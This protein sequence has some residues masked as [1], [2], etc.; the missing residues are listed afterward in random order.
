MVGVRDVYI[1]SSSMINVDRHFNRGYKELAGVVVKDVIEG[2]SVE[3]PDYIVVS[4]MFAE[5]SLNQLD[6]ATIL[7]Q[8]LGL[9]PVPAIRVDTGESS[10]LAAVEI[11]YSLITAGRADTVL[12]VGVEKATEFPTRVT[13]RFL[14]KVLDYEVEVLRNIT[15]P[16]YAALIMKEYMKRYRVSR[17][18]LTIWPVK[19]HENALRNPYAQLKFKITPSKVLNAI[20]ISE[21]ITLY[22]MFPIGDG[23]AA[24]IL[25][26]SKV[27]R[28]SGREVLLVRDVVS[29]TSRPLYLRDDITRFESIATLISML[30][31]KYGFRIDDAVYEIHDSYSIYAY[32]ILEELGIARRGASYKEVENLVYVNVSGGLKAR[33]HPFGATGVYQVSE[34]YNI[35]VKGAGGVRFDGT[36]GLTHSMSGPDYNSRLCLL[37]R[38]V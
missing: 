25:A 11:A 8:H 15:P 6:L 16:N 31:R 3:Q 13:N 35:M 2:A 38:V 4:S 17:E 10:G 1:A 22:D 18:E 33:G 12:V 9:K 24:L 29:A 23:A 32:I 14:S 20:K 7:T 26:S 5:S 21:P 30:R 37:E 36:F 28:K 27:A 19:M 34:V